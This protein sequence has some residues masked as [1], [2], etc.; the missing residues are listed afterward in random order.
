MKAVK[1]STGQLIEVIEW[2]HGSKKIYTEDDIP[3]FYTVDELDFNIPESEEEVTI[4]AYVARDRVD[5]ELN[6]FTEMPTECNMDSLHAYW[7]GE[8]GSLLLHKECENMFENLD[9]KTV[10]EVTITIKPK[11]K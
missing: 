9:Y 2:S 10:Q 1:K 11:K 5:G 3:V 4:D 6:I 8:K 7:V